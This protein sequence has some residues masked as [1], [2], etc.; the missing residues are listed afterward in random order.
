[1]SATSGFGTTNLLGTGEGTLNLPTTASSGVH[2]TITLTSSVKDGSPIRIGDV[3]LD[4]NG[5]RFGTVKSVSGKSI[6]VALDEG[7]TFPGSVSVA[8]P[9]APLINFNIIIDPG[10]VATPSAAESISIL[11]LGAHS[12]FEFLTKPSALYGSISVIQT[13]QEFISLVKMYLSSNSGREVL[14][15]MLVEYLT[16]FSKINSVYRSFSAI[17]TK[18]TKEFLNSLASM[19]LAVVKDMLLD[20]DFENLRYIT[21]DDLSQTGKLTKAL[22]FIGDELAEGRDFV[23][24]DETPSRIGLDDY[25][26]ADDLLD[27]EQITQTEELDGETLDY[28]IEE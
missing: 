16:A 15:S 22:S 14:S 21:T 5:T 17:V 11:S 26:Q 7:K 1:M 19:G 20:L 27:D 28:L 10:V 18:E 3:L 13:N 6:K 9:V 23:Y 12:Y 2:D 4:S 25:S 24:L 8:P